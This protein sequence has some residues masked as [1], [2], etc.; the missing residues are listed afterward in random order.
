[1]I[2]SADEAELAEAHERLTARAA[3]AP[4]IGEIRRLDPAQ[5]REL[6][7]PLAPGLSAVHLAGSGR[8][9]G[10]QLRRALLSAAERRGAKFVEG[11][12]AFRA[13]GTVAS[14]SGPLEADSVVV[15]AGA[16]S[17]ELLAPLGIDPAGDAAPRP[18]QPLRPA[19]H[20]HGGV[21]GGDAPHQPLP[22]GLRRRPGGG[23]RDPRAGR[24]ASTTA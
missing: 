19:G 16:W 2:V 15:A 4:E 20:G 13:D 11:E 23:G 7:P 18:D 10:H 12:V 1:M 24:P 14:P 22:P 3:D 17:R 21:A 8:V 5:A 9:D 6:F